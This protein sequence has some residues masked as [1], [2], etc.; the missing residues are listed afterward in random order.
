M[1]WVRLA[2][3]SIWLV[4]LLRA[5][6]AAA[7]SIETVEVEHTSETY[8]VGFQVILAARTLEVSQVLADYA[9]WPKLS[10]NITQARLDDSL[11][12][13]GQRIEVTFHAC[14]LARLICRS[15]RQL[16]DLERRADGFTFVSTF[17]PG[18]ADFA[19]GF[20]RWQLHSVDAN[21]TRL[22]YDS[23]FVLA[24]R[25]PPLIGPWLMKRELRREI[26]ASAAKLE[27]LAARR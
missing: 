6:G 21:T 16:K 5:G 27:E 3:L 23:A 12:A 10:D 24:F 7:Y 13:G 18:Q 22:R 2:I 11:P 1:P 17:V 19:S 20:E 25:L 15:L 4:A 14:V 9:M 26:L 8:V